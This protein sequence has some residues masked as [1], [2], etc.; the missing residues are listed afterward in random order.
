[1]NLQVRIRFFDGLQVGS[2]F[3][4]GRILVAGWQLC[5]GHIGWPYRKPCLG[6]LSLGLFLTSDPHNEILIKGQRAEF[7]KSMQGCGVMTG[8]MVNNVVMPILLSQR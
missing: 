7:V 3:V 2:L 6:H 8:T 4:H 1:M 5:F